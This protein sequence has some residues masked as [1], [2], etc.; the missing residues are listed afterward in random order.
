MHSS[1]IWRR[2]QTMSPTGCLYMLKSKRLTVVFLHHVSKVESWILLNNL[3]INNLNNP[4]WIV[5]VIRRTSHSNNS[6]T[7]LFDSLSRLVIEINGNNI[8]QP[9]LLYITGNP[10]RK[11][12]L[13]RRML[14]KSPHFKLYGEPPGTGRIGAVYFWT[15]T[16]NV[17]CLAAVKMRPFK[18]RKY[19]YKI[20]GRL[21]TRDAGHRIQM[22]RLHLW[23]SA[24]D[25]PYHPPKQLWET[26]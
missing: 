7:D 10:L 11:W 12:H 8:D 16:R 14:A 25:S 24:Y 6:M 3:Y 26:T 23:E 18:D 21:F 4:W 22:E 2:R 17:L 1:S 19:L 5:G 13:N 15:T 20:P 9:S